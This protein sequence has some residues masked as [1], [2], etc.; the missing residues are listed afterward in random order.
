MGRV[1]QIRVSAWTFDE[2]DVEKTWP[3]LNRLVWEKGEFMNPARGVMELA[4]AAFVAVDACLLPDT[5]VNA[6][7]QDARHA[8]SIRLKI[9]AALGDWDAKTADRLTYELEDALDELEKTA[10]GL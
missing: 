1:L 8:E 5:Q 9:E 3:S 4:H 6:L 10:K 7:A 2:K